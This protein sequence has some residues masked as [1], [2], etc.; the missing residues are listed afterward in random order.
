[1]QI[2]AFADAAD[3]R[4]HLPHLFQCGLHRRYQIVI[5]VPGLDT[6][7]QRLMKLINGLHLLIGHHDSPL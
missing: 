6:V 4:P 7:K 1:M 2:I 3:T 5:N